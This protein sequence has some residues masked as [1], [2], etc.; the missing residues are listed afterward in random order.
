MEDCAESCCLQLHSVYNIG[1]GGL[2]NAGVIFNAHALALQL[3]THGWG[4]N[5]RLQTS[6]RGI[7]GCSKPRGPRANDDNT[8]CVCAVGF[9][10]HGKGRLLFFVVLCLFLP[11]LLFLLLAFRQLLFKILHLGKV[12]VGLVWCRALGFI[13]GRW[14]RFFRGLFFASLLATLAF[15]H[16]AFLSFGGLALV[17][18][19]ERFYQCVVPR[20]SSLTCFVQNVLQFLVIHLHH[21]F[22]SVLGVECF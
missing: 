20:A 15:R 10:I 1:T 13:V 7:D 3:A 6:T 4:S 8:F 16:G 5:H 2:I 21:F 14:R 18:G 17:L 22:G 19:L 12:Q 11:L 9:E